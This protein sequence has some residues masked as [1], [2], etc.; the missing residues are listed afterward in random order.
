M[1]VDDILIMPY[2]YATVLWF[3]EHPPRWWLILDVS[4]VKSSDDGTD[5]KT[6]ATL[7]LTRGVP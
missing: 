6:E 4:A 1:L 3:L 5:G 2:S 7:P